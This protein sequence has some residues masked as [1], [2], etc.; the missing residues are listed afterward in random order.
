MYGCF[1][2]WLVRAFTDLIEMSKVVGMNL[3][4]Y[5][6]DFPNS[7][8]TSN[9]AVGISNKDSSMPHQAILWRIL[10]IKHECGSGMFTFEG[11]TGCLILC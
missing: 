9:T 7:L 6:R 11:V 5:F 8:K 3:Y 1:E 4:V 10:R 2:H